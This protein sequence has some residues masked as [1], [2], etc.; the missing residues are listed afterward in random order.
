MI[1]PVFSLFKRILNKP[2]SVDKIP[3][4]KWD[5]F[6]TYEDNEN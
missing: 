6:L 3:S 4:C 1:S 5:L 2:P